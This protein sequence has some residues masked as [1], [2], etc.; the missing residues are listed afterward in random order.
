MPQSSRNIRAPQELAAT[1][2]RNFRTFLLMQQFA[3]KEIGARIALARNERGLSQEELSDM[4]SGFS[5]RSLQDY[6]AG[7]TIP[8]KHLR[9]L[10]RLLKKPEEW[11]LYGDDNEQEAPDAPSDERLREI[12]REELGDLVQIL[13]RIEGRTAGGSG[14]LDEEQT[15]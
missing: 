10:G 1:K 12:F 11:F 3:A 2:A 14:G 6:E 7:V 5:K 15:G 4:A 9:E 13:E 8:Y